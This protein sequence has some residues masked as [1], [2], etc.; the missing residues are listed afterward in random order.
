MSHKVERMWIVWEQQRR[1][2]ELA[3]RLSCSFHVFDLKGLRR[4]PVS[5]AGTVALLAR[6]RPRYLFVQNPSMILAGLACLYGMVTRNVV[7]VDRHT[8]F[9]LN[10]PKTFSIWRTVFLTLHYLTL[11]TA[12]LTIVTN[13]YLAKLVREAGGRPFVLPDPI[14]VL[15]PMSVSHLEG[16]RNVLF[17]SSFGDDEPVAEVLEAARQLQLPDVRIYIS[18][19]PRRGTVDWS[20]HAPSNVAFTGFIPTGDYVSLLFAV[21]AV[22]VLTTADHCMLCGCYE[23]VAAHKPLITSDKEDLREYFRGAEFVEAQAD[24]IVRGLRRV[25]ADLSTYQERTAAM[26]DEM[27]RRWADAFSD[28]EE[29]LAKAARGSSSAADLGT[30][31][32]GQA[33]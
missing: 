12:S 15:S 23:A 30:R 26:G 9:L 2:E 1:S 27:I 29:E 5:I 8:T 24:S 22:I 20:A 13:S 31:S 4:Y 10:K 14:P 21:D 18:G 6:H 33:T 25:L 32:R 3:R 16:R 7:V 17:V 11:R 19:N 28:F